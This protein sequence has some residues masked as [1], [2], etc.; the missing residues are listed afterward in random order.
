MK[1]IPLIKTAQ[2]YWKLYKTT[3]RISQWTTHLK[4]LTLHV[5]LMRRNLKSTSILRGEWNDHRAR[6]CCQPGLKCC[7]SLFSSHRTKALLPNNRLYLLYDRFVHFRLPQVTSKTFL[8]WSAQKFL[9]TRQSTCLSKWPEMIYVTYV[10]AIYTC[11]K[12]DKYKYKH[13]YKYKY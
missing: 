12:S 2:L 4:K 11:T 6:W 9:W 13:K 3:V 5:H 10:Y 1:T 8:C 7:R